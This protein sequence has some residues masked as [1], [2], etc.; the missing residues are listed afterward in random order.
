MFST[1]TCFLCGAQQS[2]VLFLKFRF[3]HLGFWI[4]VVF[5]GSFILVFMN[6]WYVTFGSIISIK[7]YCDKKKK[8]K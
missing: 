6:Y 3:I 4:V 5:L 7:H 1:D 2:F 8:K